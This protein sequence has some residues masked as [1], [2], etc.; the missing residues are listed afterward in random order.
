MSVYLGDQ[1]VIQLRRTGQPVG[2]CLE[3][4][5]VDVDAKRISVEFGGPCPFITGDQVEVRRVDAGDLELLAGVTG[6]QDVTRWA[7]VDDAGGIRFYDSYSLAVSG[8]KASALDLVLPSGVQDITLDVVNLRSKCVAQM[9]SWEITTE[10]ETVD[11]TTLGEQYRF[12]YDEGLISGQGRITAIWDY[13]YTQCED[14][15]DIANSELAHYF[16]QL[17]IRFKEGSKFKGLFYIYQSQSESV[18]YDCDCIVTSVG[19]SFAPE[20]VIDSRIE[21]VTTGMVQLRQGNLPSYLTQEI[22][23]PNLLNLEE[24]PGSIEIESG[25]D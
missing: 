14:S 1:G 18:W 2:F 5:D 11:T 24:G 13:K 9:R 21:F 4:A 10:R 6:E 15:E 7:H 8:G 25:L 19:M 20:F 22:L 16:S 17:V 3:P 23:P 12:R